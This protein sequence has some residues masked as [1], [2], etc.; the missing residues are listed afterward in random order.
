[1]TLKKIV[2]MRLAFST[3]AFKKFSLTEAIHLISDIGYDGVEILCDI[4]HAYPRTLSEQAIVE[5]KNCINKEGIS[6]ANLN[7]FTLFAIGDVYHPSWIEPD[8]Q[9]RKLRIEHTI[10]CIVL[11]KKLGSESISVEPGG[12]VDLRTLDRNALIKIFR[13]SLLEILPVAEREGIKILI[14]PEPNL[15][16]EN[17]KQFLEFVRLTASD[18]VK[19]NFDIGHFFCVNED[20]PTTIYNLSNYIEHFHV[21]DIS[22]ERLHNHLLLGEGVIDFKTVFKAIH[23][24]GFEGYCTVELY[25]YQDC[26]EYAARKSME[27]LD[28]LIF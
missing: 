18:L 9:Q 26:P 12:P 3:N 27:F 16:I 8:S 11:A 22:V 19:L 15:L 28:D 24:I 2:I 1:M 23:D 21:E 25:P 13:N 5:I 20:L 6:I 4:P 10:D 17:S 14:E 7:A